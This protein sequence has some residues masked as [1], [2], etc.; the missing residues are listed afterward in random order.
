MPRRKRAA[1]GFVLVALA[2]AGCVRTGGGDDASGLDGRMPPP[3][4]APL[5]SD[6][7]STTTSTRSAQSG[8]TSSTTPTTP[9]TRSPGAATVTTSASI[10]DDVGDPSITLEQRPAWAD[11]AGATLQRSSAG[12]ELRVSLAA[13][14]PTVAPDDDHTMN[15]ATFFDVD[16]DG[17]VDYEV[18]VTLADNGWGPAYFD[19][20]RDRAWYAERSG[21]AVTVD[22]DEVV[23][24]FGL[25]HL[26][27]A[28]RI[29]W[30]L[31][32][33]WGRYEAIGTPTMARD[34]APNGGRPADFPA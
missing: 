19:D 1:A 5:T 6:A 30:A 3:T 29:R 24:R 21:V 32:S 14:P 17:V 25:N 26:G 18:W 12:Y 22:G 16:G 33:E 8:V 7:A 34:Q 28:D 2:V 23:L 11:L 13:A 10:T 27:G 9:T 20:G 4:F 15:I 31:S